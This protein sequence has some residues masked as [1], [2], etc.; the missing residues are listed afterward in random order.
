MSH[1]TADALP[2]ASSAANAHDGL[3][4]A[5]G[6]PEKP[7]QAN[8]F[9]T[10]I[11]NDQFA[12]SP[13]PSAQVLVLAPNRF[14]ISDELFQTQATQV[15]YTQPVAE[16]MDVS[17]SS[18][19]VAPWAGIEIQQNV[20]GR[21]HEL[22][23]A[24][25][26]GETELARVGYEALLRMGV[27]NA[28]VYH[29]LAVFAEIARNRMLAEQLFSSALQLEPNNAELLCDTGYHLELNG[30]IEG[31]TQFY[32]RAIESDPSHIRSHNHLAMALAKSNRIRE[33]KSHFRKAGLGDAEIQQ[34]LESLKH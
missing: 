14:T 19:T 24:E 10:R 30:D 5:F 2:Q 6:S 27:A 31:A 33:A 32:Q 8:A 11:P 13:L 20:E 12:F 3:M 26:R 16:T 15:S 18:R 25:L 28:L 9:T 4:G 7:W 1:S 34:N 17:R 22:R 21:I 29:R 23:Q